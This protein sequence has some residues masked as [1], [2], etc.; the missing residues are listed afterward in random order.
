MRE[1]DKKI[2]SEAIKKRVEDVYLEIRLIFNVESVN[3][4][5][6]YTRNQ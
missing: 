6:L 3:A 1:E 4:R 5:L 2:S